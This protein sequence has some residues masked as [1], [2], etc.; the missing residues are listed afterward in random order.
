MT[1][2]ICRLRLSPASYL[3][4][5]VWALCSAAVGCDESDKQV[6]LRG[7]IGER[8]PACPEQGCP[9]FSDCECATCTSFGFDPEAKQLLNCATGFWELRRECPGGVV[10]ECLEHAAYK[11]SCL[12]ADGGEV[13]LND[14]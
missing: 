5:T 10:V 3:F 14:S 1:Y 11:L 6:E 7:K 8:C 2:R 13:P 9:A 4:A 12:D